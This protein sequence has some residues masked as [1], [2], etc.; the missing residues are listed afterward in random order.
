MSGQLTAEQIDNY[1]RAI[2]ELRGATDF[3]IQ[4]Y[5]DRLQSVIDASDT[6][7]VRGCGL[8]RKGHGSHDHVFMAR[9]EV[10]TT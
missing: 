8:P 9:P 2:P 3:E 10:P 7:D 6:C 1:R 5:R 4:K